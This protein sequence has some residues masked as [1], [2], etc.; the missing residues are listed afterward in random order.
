MNLIVA[1]NEQIWPFCMFESKFS[2][3]WHVTFPNSI[4]DRGQWSKIYNLCIDICS[5]YQNEASGTHSSLPYMCSKSARNFWYPKSAIFQDSGWPCPTKFSFL[6]FLPDVPMH[7]SFNWSKFHHG[8]LASFR[9]IIF[10]LFND[11]R[12]IDFWLHVCRS[13]TKLILFLIGCSFHCCC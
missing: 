4:E 10:W 2:P 8:V 5:K 1:K 7:K 13:I 6:K 3:D 12:E 11:I 9:D